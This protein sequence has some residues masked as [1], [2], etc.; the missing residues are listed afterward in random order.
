MWSQ[1]M[2]SRGKSVRAMVLLAALAAGLMSGVPGQAGAGGSSRSPFAGHYDLGDDLCRITISDSGRVSDSERVI[3][4]RITD[5]GFMRL[6][7]PFG[8]GG[9][10]P[11]SRGGGRST[12][13]HE[14][15]AALDEYG[16]L[17][18]V[19]TYQNRCGVVLT[20]EVFWI[21]CG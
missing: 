13:T 2:M 14:G 1:S 3:S 8:I 7:V 20:L 5:D 12:I 9:G 15:I 21:R 19:L 16:N 4:G 17:Y 6:T 11:G 10:V 18:A